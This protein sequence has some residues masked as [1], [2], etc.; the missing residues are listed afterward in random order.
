MSPVVWF[1]LR[2]IARSEVEPQVGRFKGI[3]RVVLEGR[4]ALAISLSEH[5]VIRALQ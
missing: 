2:G 3:R 5:W 4:R 1:R